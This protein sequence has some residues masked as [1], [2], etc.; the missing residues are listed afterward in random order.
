MQ[1]PDAG[2]KSTPEKCAPGS[3][4]ARDPPRPK[5]SL[6][7]SRKNKKLLRMGGRAGLCVYSETNPVPYIGSAKSCVMGCRRQEDWTGTGQRTSLGELHLTSL[8]G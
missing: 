7:L 6:P 8:E 2:L 1:A 5:Q 4:L 3:S